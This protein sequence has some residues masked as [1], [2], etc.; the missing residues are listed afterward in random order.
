LKRAFFSML[1]LTIIWGSTFPLQK[2]VLV[3]IS[4]FIYNSMRFSLA[5]ILSYLIW[6]FGSIKYGAILGLFLSCGYITQI[7]GL[8][9]T[10][11]SK[12]GFITSLYV[13]LVPL[14]S[15][16]LE[17]KKVSV[18]QLLGFCFAF[19]GMYL[20][21]GGVDGFNFGDFLNLLCA[22]SF[23]FHVVMITIFSNKVHHSKLLTPQFLTTALINSFLGI[24]GK[25][26]ITFPILGV[27]IYT[28]IFA[29]VY[30]IYIQTKYQK[31][32][33]SNTSALI[34]SGE[35]VFSAIFSYLILHEKMTVFQIVGAGLL[36]T[37]ILMSSVGMDE[38]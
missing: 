38:I 26:K 6:G 21:S 9:M 1:I 3:G 16:F 4:P 19:I 7:W 22:V 5:S 15:Y 2:I 12:S 11:A 37:A 14:I 13:V 30:G 27:V 36:L 35:P 17:R 24:H 20:L 33:G 10:T 32:I 8:T 31:R 28:A 18:L 34:F 23:A 29:T 25:W